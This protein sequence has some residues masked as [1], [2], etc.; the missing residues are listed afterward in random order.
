[1]VKKLLVVMAVAALVS[2]VSF[3]VLAAMGGFPPASWGPQ[4][5]GPDGPP[6]NN[7]RRDAGP[8]VTR[9]LPYS[10]S[11]RLEVSLPAEITVTQGAEP[12]FTI[13]GPQNIIDD[14]QLEDGVLEGR[15]GPAYR[16]RWPRHYRGRLRIDVVTPNTHEFHLAGA[17]KL[18]IRNFDQD[19]LI[20][21]I[22]GAADVDAQGRARRLEAHIAG[23][24]HLDM[25][26]LPVQDAEV[27][28]AGAG[29][30]QLD[31]RN[32]SEV[33]ISGAGHVQFR[34][35]PARSEAHTS[36]FG[37]VGYGESCTD[38]P[39]PASSAS[40]AVPAAPAAPAPKPN[41]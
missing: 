31:A 20:L 41:V 27:S 30:A 8:E 4:G 29:D 17:Q 18:S 12:R 38:L 25:G 2:V 36:G 23:A 24:G 15:Y 16:H 32:S 37:G 21:H 5:W 28:I 11:D 1:V 19:S 6:W 10:G 40:P 26:S 35:R 34:C 14:L 9:T 22:A 13:T 33:S 7:R 3:S 39:P